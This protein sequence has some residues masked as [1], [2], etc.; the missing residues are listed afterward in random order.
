[1]AIPQHNPAGQPDHCPE[2]E[3]RVRITPAH[4]EGTAPCPRCGALLKFFVRESAVYFQATSHVPEPT[5][6]STLAFNLLEVGKRVRITHGPFENFEG[7]IAG[8]D[9]EQQTVVLTVEIF[10]CPTRVDLKPWQVEMI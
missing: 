7:D 5:L 3:E 6:L 2:C 9:H 4:L 8:F 10:D 1:M